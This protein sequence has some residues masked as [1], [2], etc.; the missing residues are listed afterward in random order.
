[1]ED[2]R[3]PRRRQP[4]CQ[5]ETSVYNPPCCRPRPAAP[6]C[7][8]RRR[9]ARWAAGLAGAS[10]RRRG[11]SWRGRGGGRAA[12]L[13][14]GGERRVLGARRGRQGQAR[15]NDVAVARMLARRRGVGGNRRLGLAKREKA[16]GPGQRVAVSSAS[17]GWEHRAEELGE[18]RPSCGGGP[19]G[20]PSVTQGQ[21]RWPGRPPRSAPPLHAT[22]CRRP[23][24]GQSAWCGPSGAG[25]RGGPSQSPQFRPHATGP[26]TPH[27]CSRCRLSL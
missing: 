16:E 5:G 6:G 26:R 24:C 11:R 10:R 1:M 15:L 7:R 14:R 27:C 23:L 9:L 19:G 4:P 17:R 2:P 8:A 25:R 20:D 18:G 3:P 12:E 13:V 22:H 21:P